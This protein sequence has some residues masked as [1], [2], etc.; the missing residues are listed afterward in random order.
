MV[1]D[2]LQATG[3]ITAGGVITCFGD[4]LGLE[5]RTE[6]GRRLLQ[7]IEDRRTGASHLPQLAYALE[8]YFEKRTWLF[9]TPEDLS[10]IHI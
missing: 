7:E 8:K 6:M 1:G 5:A 10:L 9:V 2:G 3:H 4:T